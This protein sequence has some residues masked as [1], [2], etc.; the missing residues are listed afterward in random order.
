M[1]GEGPIRRGKD[2][3]RVSKPPHTGVMEFKVAHRA[4]GMGHIQGL[5]KIG[6]GRQYRWHLAFTRH[7]WRAKQGTGVGEGTHHENSC[8]NEGRDWVP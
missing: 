7:E 1:G 4:V 8:A 6:N 5:R 2:S 3:P